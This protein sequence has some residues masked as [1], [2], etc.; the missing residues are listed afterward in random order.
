MDRAN[1]LDP[2]CLVRR[3]AEE[4]SAPDTRVLLLLHNLAARL[5][6]LEF[7]ANRLRL[8][9]VGV[10]NELRQR[11]IADGRTGVLQEPRA[12][13]LVARGEFQ[14]APPWERGTVENR[15]RAYLPVEG[16]GC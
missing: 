14:V 1:V 12:R 10:R 6:A 9:R 11:A 4:V 8:S 15:G 2:G 3:D 16:C 5:V 7:D 13:D